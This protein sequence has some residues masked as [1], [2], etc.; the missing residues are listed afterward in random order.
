MLKFESTSQLPDTLGRK[1]AGAV[2]GGAVSR[3]GRVGLFDSQ[4][5]TGGTHPRL[6]EAHK[7]IY[8]FFFFGIVLFWCPLSLLRATNATDITGRFPQNPTVVLPPSHLA[9][10]PC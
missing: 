8:F 9:E 6:V 3:T 1:G 2:G 10:F 5:T 7:R 4:G